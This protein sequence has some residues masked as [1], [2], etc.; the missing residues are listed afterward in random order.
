MTVLDFWATW[1]VPCI[2]EIPSFNQLQKDWA[3]KGVVV[4]G[5]NM[6]E[7]SAALVKPFLA[8]H[9][10]EYSVALA[11]DAIKKQYGVGDELPV[12]V[13]LDRSGKEVK[14][15]EGFTKEDELRA[16]VQSALGG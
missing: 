10:M 9:P 1:C 7:D 15:F 8:K 5:V 16:A 12:T 13:I 2:Q 6:D 11:S 14:R 4:V 3:G